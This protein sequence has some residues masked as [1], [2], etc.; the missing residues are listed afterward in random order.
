MKSYAKEKTKTIKFYLL[1]LPLYSPFHSLW[2]ALHH[3]NCR[4]RC[5]SQGSCEEVEPYSQE[6]DPLSHSMLSVHCCPPFYTQQ[7]MYCVISVVPVC[8]L[9]VIVQVFATV[10]FYFTPSQAT[11]PTPG[12]KCKCGFT[13]QCQLPWFVF[14]QSISMEG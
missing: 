5:L 6:Q 7:L 11:A 14:G 4:R 8:L 2:S 9:E 1:S 12:V 13:D 3:E 10:L